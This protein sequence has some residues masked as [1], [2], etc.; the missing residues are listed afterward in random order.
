[1]KKGNLIIL[2]VLVILVSLVIGPLG[3]LISLTGLGVPPLWIQFLLLVLTILS[4]LGF[5]YV[6][7]DKYKHYDSDKFLVYFLSL[8]VLSFII[9]SYNQTLIINKSIQFI[10]ALVFFLAPILAML[11]FTSLFKIKNFFIRFY[12]VIG[13]L[14]SVVGVIEQGAYISLVYVMEPSKYANIVVTS[15]MVSGA[16]LSYIKILQNWI[17]G[18]VLIWGGLKKQPR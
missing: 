16:V 2:G 11:F 17:L 1:M 15:K 5:K 18:G 12:A 13:L 14:I 9:R 7:N 3:I 4:L 8:T 10:A 6:I